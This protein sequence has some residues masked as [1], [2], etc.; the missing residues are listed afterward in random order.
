MNKIKYFIED[1]LLPQLNEDWLR[2][3]GV[4]AKQYNK[5]R[6]V[7]I[8]EPYL[9]VLELTG[10][11]LEKIIEAYGNYRDGKLLPSIHTNCLYH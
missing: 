8:G 7:E 11:K 4:T 1:M 3:S 2:G 6:E 10:E 5:S 9:L